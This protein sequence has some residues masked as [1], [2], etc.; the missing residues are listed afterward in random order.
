M[1]ANFGHELKVCAHAGC[2]NGNSGHCW[3]WK[4]YLCAVLLRNPFCSTEMRLL[5]YV[6][7]IFPRECGDCLKQTLLPPPIQLYINPAVL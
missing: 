4:G 7:A 1:S 6:A 2:L 3:D 5:C